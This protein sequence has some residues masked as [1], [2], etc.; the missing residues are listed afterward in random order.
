MRIWVDVITWVQRRKHFNQDTFPST[1][2]LVRVICVLIKSSNSNRVR[3]D[4][5]VNKLKI[6]PESIKKDVLIVFWR[7]QN[8]TLTLQQ[9][10]SYLPV[11]NQSP[12]AFTGVCVL[13][14]WVTHLQSWKDSLPDRKKKVKI[15]CENCFTRDSGSSGLK[16]CHCME[17]LPCFA[18]VLGERDAVVVLDPCFSFL[19]QNFSSERLSHLLT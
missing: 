3:K 7:L 1:F 4:R 11:Q 19:F 15:R 14:H 9:D 18:P 12:A 17:V 6:R 5:R 2:V 13:S 16:E 10:G 8:L